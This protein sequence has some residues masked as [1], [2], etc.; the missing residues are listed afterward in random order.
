[1]RNADVRCPFRLPAGCGQNSVFSC[2]RLPGNDIMMEYEFFMM[3][4]KAA[5]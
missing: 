1:M 2:S 4:M 3:G 5:V